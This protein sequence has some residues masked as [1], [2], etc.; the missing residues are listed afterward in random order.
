MTPE[1]NRESA[2]SSATFEGVPIW[3]GWEIHPVNRY[4]D[5]GGAAFHSSERYK[6]AE[7][8]IERS[9][10]PELTREKSSSGS[11]CPRGTIVLPF[12]KEY[13]TADTEDFTISPAYH[14]LSCREPLPQRLVA[15]F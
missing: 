10:C 11:T 4:R 3:K 15:R 5:P 1:R 12:G 9:P 6:L 2:T 7:R 8:S 14:H 13:R